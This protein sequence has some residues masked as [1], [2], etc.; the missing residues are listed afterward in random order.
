MALQIA[1]E[2][3]PTEAYFENLILLNL[4]AWRDTTTQRTDIHYWRTTVGDEVDFVIETPNAVIPIETKSIKRVH[5]GDAKH[6]N[7]FWQ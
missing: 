4:L 3:S 1:W 7:T 5:I 6:L 2:D